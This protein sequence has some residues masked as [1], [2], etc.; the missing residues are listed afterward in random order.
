MIVISYADFASNTQKYLDAAKF[1]GLKVKP[2]KKAS[3]S[4]KQQKMLADLDAITGIV[5]SNID[6]DEI[7]TEE[8]LK[9]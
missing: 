9:H 2:E 4:R 8:I 7:K 5:P 3:L 6:F 1:S